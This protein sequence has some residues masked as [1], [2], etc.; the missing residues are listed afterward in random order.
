VGFVINGPIE[1]YAIP[2]A[3]SFTIYHFNEQLSARRIEF[4]REHIRP[5][6]PYFYSYLGI[7][8]FFNDPILKIIDI[9]GNDKHVLRL[10]KAISKPGSIIHQEHYVKS[11]V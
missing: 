2:Y 11:Y 1:N 9:F 3:I 10:Y 5:F 6:S 4:T 8:E 7:G